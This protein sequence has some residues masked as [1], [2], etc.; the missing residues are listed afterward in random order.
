MY[1]ILHNQPGWGNMS[2]M[3]TEQPSTQMEVDESAPAIPAGEEDVAPAAGEEA[4]PK[5]V[6][7]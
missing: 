7:V 3:A 5:E 1:R 4:A 6:V 2:D